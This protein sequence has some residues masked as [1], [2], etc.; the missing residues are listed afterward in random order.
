MNYKLIENNL[1]LRPI[2]KILINRG[3][4]KEEV[5]HYLNTDKNDLIDFSFLK[6]I[7]KGVDLIRKHIN[8]KSHILVVVDSDVDG[9][10][11][12]AILLNYLYD[13]YGEE[14]IKN[15]DYFLHSGKQHGAEDFVQQSKDKIEFYDLIICPDA[16]SNEIEL[17]KTLQ[18]KR[19]DVLV[20]DHHE[21]E[22]ESEYAC[23]IN[24][25]LGD[26]PNKTLSGGG[27]VY[28][29]CCYIDYLQGTN[30]ASKYIDLC[31][32][33]LISDMMDIRNFET[34]YLIDEGLK[35]VNSSFIQLM[36]GKAK[37]K[38]GDSLTPIGVAFYITPAINATIR[39]G[40][41][42]EKE[43]LFK[44]LLHYE[45]GKLI[46]STKRGC[47]GQNELL[48][49]QACRNCT[50]I[51]NRQTKDRDKALSFVEELIQ[52]DGLNND[53]ILIIPLKE[54]GK[55][56]TNITG[57]IAN[58]LMSKYQ[59]P[60]LLLHKRE[61]E[62]NITWEGSG[63]NYGK[64]DFEDFRGFIADSGW[65]MYAQ[66]HASAFGA[67]FSDMDLLNFKNYSNAKLAN[68]NFQPCYLVDFIYQEDNVDKDTILEIAS[69]SDIYGQ[70]IDEPFVAVENIKVT[71]DNLKL[72]SADKN[73]T[74]KISLSNGIDLIKFG[75][76]KEEY[77][78]LL[79]PFGY[80][81]INIIGKCGQN[82]WMGNIS[83]QILVE[84]YEITEE[85][86]YY[87]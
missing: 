43:I 18:E 60:V 20:L 30:F 69:Y 21:V 8:N 11:S 36:H 70:C 54:S 27:V 23:I 53:K 75:S 62:G 59:K 14:C 45:A 65:A 25:Q 68:Y 46:P 41:Q 87:F 51:K 66:G 84:D 83:A 82:N 32:L 55:V 79:S 86:K 16:G 47:K 29:F 31:A 33:A 74:L 72:L 49:D 77:E 52:Q 48:V 37:Y 76:S 38:I 81:K 34:K 58:Q 15:I 6:N 61:Y 24:N 3:I 5:F 22:I 63:R 4:S 67:G 7:D 78:N 44:S 35:T 57:L 39:V 40:S 56:P 19:I 12:A 28:K 26:Y 80:I 10:A 2:E 71:K 42:E 1:S 17:H 9:Y 13:V 64:S 50:N 85:C 73:P